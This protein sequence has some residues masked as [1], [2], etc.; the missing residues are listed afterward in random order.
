MNQLYNPNCV[1]LSGLR[2]LDDD[3]Q[4]APNS[5]KSLYFKEEAVNQLDYITSSCFGNMVNPSF[6]PSWNEHWDD[7]ASSPQGASALVIPP[8]KLEVENGRMFNVV[9]DLKMEIEGGF[10]QEGVVVPVLAEAYYF[11]N[12]GPEPL[13]RDT[14]HYEEV[15]FTAPTNYQSDQY[16]SVTAGSPIALTYEFYIKMSPR[17]SDLS[18]YLS[19]IV[20]NKDDNNILTISGGKS[21]TLFMMSVPT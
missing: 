15:S 3:V 8:E 19:F 13:R 18:Q 10:L 21:T 4:I 5:F 1:T 6:T 14:I 12:S 16:S 2:K 17:K 7:K 9:L 20:S 11:D